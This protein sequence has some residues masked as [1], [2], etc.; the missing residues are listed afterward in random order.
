MSLTKAKL[1][2]QV[3]T[4]RNAAAVFLVDTIQLFNKTGE[5]ITDGESIPV[6]ATAQTLACRVINRSGASR[7]QV[8]AQQRSTRMTFFDAT[9]R[10]QLPYGTAVKVNDRLKFTDVKTARVITL[11]VVFVP[12]QHDFMGAFIVGCEEAQ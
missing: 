6:Y 10:V 11:E 4:I 3:V 2:A 9:Y 5:T 7:T 12:A 8:A 1:L